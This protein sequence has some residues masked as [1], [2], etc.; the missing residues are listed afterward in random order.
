MT[1]GPLATTGDTEDGLVE[2][3]VARTEG[4]MRPERC[5]IA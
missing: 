4:N 2:G 5:L 3:S 1:V